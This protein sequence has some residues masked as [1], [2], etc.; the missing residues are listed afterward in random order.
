MARI[1]VCGGN[2]AGKSTLGKALAS[3]LDYK[4]EDIENYY[5]PKENPEYEYA[6]SRTREEVAELLLADLKQ[7][8]DF[9]LASV[10]ADYGKEVEELFDIAVY[11][12]VPKEVREKRVYERSYKQF[13]ERM[14][15]GG[16]L[17]ESEKRFFD[18]VAQRPDD[19]AE[20]WLN[21]MSI[22]IIKVD[23]TKPIEKS[24]EEIKRRLSE[25]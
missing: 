5:F 21:D 23:G 7:Y 18:M 24:V 11:I 8:A 1:I 16:D 12:K 2:G 9:V 19:Y 20:K 15:P 3:E 13:G 17:Y 14:L 25:E 22:P 10:K 4:F 6:E